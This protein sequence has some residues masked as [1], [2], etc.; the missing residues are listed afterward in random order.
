MI[1]ITAR[2]NNQHDRIR[3]CD[4]NCQDHNLQVDMVKVCFPNYW[5]ELI[6]VNTIKQYNDKKYGQIWPP[7]TFNL[8]DQISLGWAFSVWYQTAVNKIYKL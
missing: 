8:D 3:T 1:Q 7:T 5:L 6:N 4:L 2:Y